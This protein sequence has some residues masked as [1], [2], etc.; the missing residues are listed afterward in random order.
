MAGGLSAGV[1]SWRG[2][3]ATYGYFR[4]AT[5]IIQMMG[6]PEPSSTPATRAAADAKNAAVAFGLLGA[7]LGIALGVAGGLAQGSSR[8]AGAAAA[9][10][11]LLGAALGGGVA[12]ALTILDYRIRDPS[13]HSL[14]LPLV[15]HGGIGA[16]VGA[17]GGLAL[18]L[19]HNSRAQAARAAAGGALGGALGAI[20]YEVVSA[21]AF[22]LAETVQTIAVS[23]GPRLVDRLLIAI[24]ASMAAGLAIGGSRAQPAP[25]R[26]PV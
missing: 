5:V 20:V 11:G 3:E 24:F 19:G 1:L 7:A 6:R 22:P 2:G 8:A 25:P 10:G 26:N 23:W 4:P 13:S 21:L 9:V 18:A 12:W 15:L 16:A 17:A 14:L